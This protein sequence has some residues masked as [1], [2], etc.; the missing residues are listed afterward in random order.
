MSNIHMQVVP[1]KLDDLVYLLASQR[2]DGLFE[3]ALVREVF[4]S[5][6]EQ[7]EAGKS[8]GLYGPKGAGKSTTLLLYASYLNQCGYDLIYISCETI[9]YWRASGEF[10]F[11]FPLFFFFKQSNCYYKCKS[12]QHTVPYRTKQQ[13][14][15][16][17]NKCVQSVPP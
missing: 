7:M 3:K 14:T 9:L 4:F 1:L 12:G 16:A 13:Q 10:S 17:Q 6:K 15:T 2:V 11:N 5:L 8:V